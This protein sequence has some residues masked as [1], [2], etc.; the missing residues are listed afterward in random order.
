MQTSSSIRVVAINIVA[1][2]LAAFTTSS[3]ILAEQNPS[4]SDITVSKGGSTGHT[5]IGDAARAARPGSRILIKPGVYDEQ[6]VIDKSLELV[7]DGEKVVIQGRD[8]EALRLEGASVTLR[9]LTIRSTA[10]AG[11]LVTKGK[12]TITKCTI[13]APSGAA[14]SVVSKAAIAAEHTIVSDSTGGFDVDSGAT[15]TLTECNISKC[16][17]YAVRVHV[18]GS[19]AKIQ[20]CSIKDCPTDGVMVTDNGKLAVLDTEMSA[21]EHS[22][23]YAHEAILV[24]KDSKI[25]NGHMQGIVSDFSH[26]MV[27]RTEISGNQW[28]G[29]YACSDS[30]VLVSDCKL[31]TN[32]YSGVRMNNAL[33]EIDDTYLTGNHECGVDARSGIYAIVRC[34]INKNGGNAIWIADQCNTTVLD[35]DL[36]ENSQGEARVESPAKLRVLPER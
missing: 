2:S 10:G 1:F 6:L 22:C 14:V 7:G 29:L 18:E 5:S 24:V 19:N 27:F 12:S 9:N 13:S 3:K 15:A 16:K 31:N 36:S 17:S 23:L 8:H 28:E 32:G 20:K 35:S 26:V 33:V 25:R 4:S 11:V 30:T 34:H 21:I